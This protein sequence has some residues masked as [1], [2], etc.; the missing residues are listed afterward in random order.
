MKELWPFRIEGRQAEKQKHCISAAKSSSFG[1]ERWLSSESLESAGLTVGLCGKVDYS[2]PKAHLTERFNNQMMSDSDSLGNDVP[3]TGEIQ[4]NIL[5]FFSSRY[6][7]K[8]IGITHTLGA[9]VLNLVSL[10][11]I[12]GI[13]EIW[14]KK[15][16]SFV[17]LTSD[18]NLPF[19]S[20]TNVG[21]KG[22]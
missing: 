13:H 3:I 10:N 4:A 15:F 17:V 2:S 19:H 14:W 11:R 7:K 12:Q 18:H 20:I 1:T 22:Q 16:Y 21:N 9:R 8:S 5:E 6:T